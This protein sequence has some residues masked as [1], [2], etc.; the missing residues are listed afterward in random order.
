[1]NNKDVV[2]KPYTME[3]PSLLPQSLD[4]LVPED[5]LV[6]VVNRVIEQLDLEPLLAK[7]KGGGTSSYHPKMMLKVL[8]YAYA[9]RSSGQQNG[10]SVYG[11]HNPSPIA[12]SQGLHGHFIR[13]WLAD[14]RAR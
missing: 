13:V 9:S 10:F 11:C 3:Q 2:F 8:A 1:M 14:S 6:R 5:H 12:E 7:Y 4:E